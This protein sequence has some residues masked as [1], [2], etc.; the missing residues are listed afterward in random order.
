MT[1]DKMYNEIN[2]ENLNILYNKPNE[3]FTLL[4]IKRNG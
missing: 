1:Y 2:A 4:N 3:L